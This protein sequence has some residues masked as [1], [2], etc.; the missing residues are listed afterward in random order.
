M[1][2]KQETL[3]FVK[4]IQSYYFEERDLNAL[5]KCFDEK[6]SWIGT[7]EKEYCKNIEDAYHALQSEFRE[8]GETLH[9]SKS[10]LEVTTLSKDV[11]MVYGILHVI[12][13]S[14]VLDEQLLRVTLLCKRTDE[15]IKLAHCHFSIADADQKEGYYYV[16]KENKINHSHLKKELENRNQQLRN[17]ML[18]IPGGVH[19]CASDQY[20][21][22]YGMSTG[23]LTLFG[24]TREEVKQEF[25]D[26]FINMIYV[27]DR[28]KV[29]QSTKA[30]LKKGD[31]I[32]LEYRVLCKDG[33]LLWILDKGRLI[34]TKNN[35]PFIYCI[36]IENTERK[37]EQEELRLALERYNVIMDQATDII[38]EW[39][40]CKD[41]LIFS[42]NWSKKFEYDP[43]HKAISKDLL[44]SLNI[45]PDDLH[46]LKK[47]MED[48]A[49][50][51][52][53][54][55][56]E[57]RI[58]NSEDHY[59]WNRIRATSQLNQE[60]LAIKA[61]GVIIDIT[62]EKQE[63]QKLLDLGQKD[64]LTGLYNKGA[65]REL[66]E[67][68]MKSKK[69][70]SYQAMMVIDVDNFKAVNDH[71]GHL[72]GDALLSNIAEVLKGQ[73]RSSDLIARIGGDEFIIYLS[74]VQDQS[75][76]EAK[77]NEVLIELNKV[78]PTKNSDPIS[79]SIG[80]ALFPQMENDYL[81]LYKCADQ[82]LYA[83]KNNGKNGVT[84]YEPNLVVDHDTNGLLRSAI[85]D[86]IE[87]ED[88]TNLDKTL[89]QYTFSMLY[90]SVNI[91]TAINQL[92]EIVGRAYD[93]SRVYIFEDSID[94][95][96]CSNT[97]EWCAPGIASE[98]DNLQNLSYE[99]Q[100][101]FYKANFDEN[102]IFYCPNTK[103]LD[104][105]LSNSLSSQYIQSLLQCAMMDGK[106]FVGF[107]GFD[108]CRENRNWTKFHIESLSLIADVLSVFLTKAHLEERLK[109]SCS[110][111]EH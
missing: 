13:N 10:N 44:R 17:L 85:S 80:I 86:A 8:F 49:Q 16:K 81:K 7:G 52:P 46:L 25:D 42:K 60:G 91:R 15:G 61:I 83:R 1:T 58:R 14:L 53:F 87:S 67:H 37:K 6:I 34:N 97:F 75:I 68:E 32:E 11:S 20:F 2:M 74:S 9:I 54:S 59:T 109:E 105:S 22:L 33:T 78:C 38:F 82:A 99:T 29:L 107:I 28:K 92:L 66:V 50:G 48:T 77:M 100:L 26:K 3:A 70:S 76:V 55:E 95:S 39:D 63:K 71:Y 108:E 98:I 101:P 51:V 40:I 65:I 12:P 19:Q 96:Y 31:Y 89:V 64:A 47:M 36:L 88:D 69:N 103:Q 41:T 21:T 90:R 56:T 24:Y 5:L 73:F 23:F 62:A 35:T 43:I 84:F 102:G 45:H 27:D 110:S 79:C 4:E 94:A 93:V 111:K 72:C 30:Q 57:F 106:N 18:N 104:N